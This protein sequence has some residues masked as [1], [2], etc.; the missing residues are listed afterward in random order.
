MMAGFHGN[1]LYQS[2]AFCWKHPWVKI[3][4]EQESLFNTLT[5]ATA[6]IKC[7]LLEIVMS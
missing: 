3:F 5:L 2:Q 4:A 7:V 6:K 1:E